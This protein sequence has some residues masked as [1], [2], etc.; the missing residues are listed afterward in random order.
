VVAGSRPKAAHASR[1]FIASRLV[2]PS[3][4]RGCSRLPQQLLEGFVVM[5]PFHW[6]LHPLHAYLRSRCRAPPSM[7]RSPTAPNTRGEDQLAKANTAQQG[8][9]LQ[10]SP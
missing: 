10:F 7:P 8:G 9:V 6:P 2:F 4:A 3:R 1:R 5:E